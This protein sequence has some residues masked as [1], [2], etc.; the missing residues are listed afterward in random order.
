MRH[1][2]AARAVSP[3]TARLVEH[4]RGRPPEGAFPTYSD[5]SVF[6]ARPVQP[7]PDWPVAL[8]VGVL[9][10][11]K[12]VALLAAAWRRVAAR[13]PDPALIIVG[14][15]S[16][17]PLIGQLRAELPLRV[18]YIPQLSSP[19][20]ARQ[21]DAATVLVLPS[22]V[23]GLPRVIIEAFARGR[24]VIATRTGGI[25]DLVDDGRQGLL[26]EVD[27]EG[28]LADALVRVLSDAECAR[29]LGAAA[30]ERF[31]RWNQSADQWAERMHAL[32]DGVLHPG[33]TGVR[34]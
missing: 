2:D 34:A 7:L 4:E 13:L 17:L 9:E 32:V 10:D 18:Q 23:E 11:I 12:N 14:R 8:F 24:G 5:L 26:V 30:L 22:R 28:G 1:A 6:A 3:Y 31:P 15:G 20:V 16:R 21:L 29:R 33:P 27:D 25:P 19:G